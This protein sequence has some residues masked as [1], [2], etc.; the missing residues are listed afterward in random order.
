MGQ[1]NWKLWPLCPWPWL[2]IPWNRGAEGQG[3]E[4]TGQ[5]WSHGGFNS[6]PFICCQGGSK[7]LWEGASPGQG[8]S[9]RAPAHTKQCFGMQQ[10]LGDSSGAAA[11]PSHPAQV[12]LNGDTSTCLSP[13]TP[14]RPPVTTVLE[15]SLP[16]HHRITGYSELQANHLDHQSPT[17]STSLDNR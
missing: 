1:E 10:C 16:S 12:I 13:R 9:S 5:P 4:G 8:H 3:G 7:H 14:L 17:H 15:T 11:F 2:L 6:K